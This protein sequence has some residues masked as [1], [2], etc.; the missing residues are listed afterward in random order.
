M[1]TT[2]Q[3]PGMRQN[4]AIQH[5]NP[6]LSVMAWEARRLRASRLTWMLA[7]TAFALFLFVIWTEHGPGTFITSYQSPHLQYTFSSNIP[8]LS[9]AWL[10]YQ[11]HRSALLLLLMALP[12]LCA[13]GVTRDLKRRTHELLMATALP[14]WAY[15]WGRYMIALL[16][17]LGLAVELLAAILVM[18]LAL[19]LS[20]GGHDYPVPDVGP[21]FVFWAALAL[22]TIVFISSA[23]FMLGTLLPRRANL[24]KI[25]VMV[26]WFIWAMIFNASV[27][28]NRV[29]DW[30]VNSDLSGTFLGRSYDRSFAEMVKA[31]G[32]G[33]TRSQAMLQR[34]FDTVQYQLPEFW[35]WLIPHLIWAAFGLVL[36]ALAAIS[37]KRFRNV[38]N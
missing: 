37:F 31:A 18:G 16:L 23:S 1:T 11:L 4:I 2:V 30:Y 19:H 5:A 27:F 12:F 20:L 8:Y 24:F 26:G 36:V 21:V 6:L 25:G 15:V 13:D 9:P 22:P 29:P 35:S 3:R 38:P 17:G 32:T 7:L 33:P 14:T 28:W 34:I 10:S